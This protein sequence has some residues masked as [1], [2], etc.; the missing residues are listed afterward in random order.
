MIRVPNLSLIK[1]ILYL[2]LFKFDFDMILILILILD[3]NFYVRLKTSYLY[4]DLL[5]RR[6]P[7]LGYF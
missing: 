4:S 1:L 3:F 5:T 2:N 7:A 6:Y